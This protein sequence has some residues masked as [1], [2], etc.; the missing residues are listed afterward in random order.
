MRRLPYHGDAF[1]GVFLLLRG[2]LGRASTSSSTF[3]DEIGGEAPTD[4]ILIKK[5]NQLQH[6]KS[7]N[8]KRKV[9]N[10]KDYT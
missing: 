7:R 5:N 1:D 4:Y 6:T 8:K 3:F 10:Q 2:C 9:K